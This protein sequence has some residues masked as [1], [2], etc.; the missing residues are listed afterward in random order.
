MRGGLQLRKCQLSICLFFME[1]R[2]RR[3]AGEVRELNLKLRSEKQLHVHCVKREGQRDSEREGKG[4]RERER[5]QSYIRF[6][7]TI[8]FTL[9]ARCSLYN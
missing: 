1:M 2:E 9:I 3:L 8:R 5:D 4:E 7:S 6:L